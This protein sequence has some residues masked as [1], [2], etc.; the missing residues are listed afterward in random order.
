MFHLWLSDGDT[1]AGV[2]TNRALYTLDDETGYNPVYWC[3]DYAVGAYDGTGANAVIT[4]PY[5]PVTEAEPAGTNYVLDDLLSDGDWIY[6]NDGGT[7]KYFLVSTVASS[8]RRLTLVGK[9]TNALVP[10]SSTFKVLK[11][12]QAFGSSYVDFTFGRFKA[13]FVDSY[14]PMVFQYDGAWLS[15]LIIK[16]LVGDRN[17]YGAKT[18]A[19]FKE[20]LYFGNV[21]ETL[22]TG[23]K[24]AQRVRWTETLDWSKSYDADYQDLPYKQ[25]ELLKLLGFGDVLIAYMTDTLY[26]GRQTNMP[27]L[28]Y[29][30]YQLETAGIAPVGMKAI[31]GFFSGQLFVGQDD[32][33][34]LTSESAVT[35]S[36][37][38][39]AKTTS[40][41]PQITRIGSVIAGEALKSTYELSATRLKVDL[42]NS[43]VVVALAK[44]TETLTDLYFWNYKSKGWSFSRNVAFSA[45]AA[46]SIT[47]QYHI[48]EVDP[49]WTY[50]GAPISNLP[51]VS[52]MAKLGAMNL[53]GFLTSGHLMQYSA[54]GT[55]HLLPMS[56]G[57]STRPLYAQLVTQNM[58]FGLPSDNKTVLELNLK[59]SDLADERLEDIRFLTEASIDGGRTWRKLGYLRI[60]PNDD[61]DTLNFR[62]TGS[63]VAFRLTTGLRS[64]PTETYPTQYEICSY[65]L[66][67]RK[68]GSE[69]QRDTSRPAT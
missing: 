29:A 46:L 26:Y 44:S 13:Y 9:P 33:Y 42:L 6:L 60:R 23:V 24:S 45:I 3:R 35:T 57:E 39:A 21:R 47:D 11:P 68:R 12:F 25:G 40:T 49:T 18:I 17:I 48:N 55:E 8:T 52:Q 41:G 51:I 43:R 30:F 15:P 38:D 19:Y 20:R 10:G 63:M 37:S 61:E 64:T 1:R 14:S 67:I 62:V 5:G 34:Y 32:I 59:I 4:V 58:E 31:V 2:V 66:R 16:N 56:T 50:D 54:V 65:S 69:Y 28:P 7:Y 27:S 53:M 36:S 22:G